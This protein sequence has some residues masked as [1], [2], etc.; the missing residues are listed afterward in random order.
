MRK[1][2]IKTFFPMLSYPTNKTVEIFLRQLPIVVKDIMLRRS[3]EVPR[4]KFVKNI[5]VLYYYLKFRYVS[6]WKKTKIKNLFGTPMKA[7]QSS[8]MTKYIH[9][10]TFLNH[11]CMYSKYVSQLVILSQY[12]S[13]ASY[14]Y[15]AIN[16]QVNNEYSN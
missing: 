7:V 5:L 2:W 9:F 16:N 13:R 12:A 15:N 6:N 10:A 1:L 14:K 3:F 8:Q 11:L 4:L